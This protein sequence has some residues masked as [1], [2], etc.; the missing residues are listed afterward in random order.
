M[1]VSG[2]GSAIPM[3]GYMVRRCGWEFLVACTWRRQLF[4][5]QMQ[6][7]YRACNPVT[8]N[9]TRPARPYAIAKTFEC[10]W[11]TI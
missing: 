6:L 7:N 5:N 10:Q 11:F 8:Y 3:L 9:V 4:L 2:V 1:D